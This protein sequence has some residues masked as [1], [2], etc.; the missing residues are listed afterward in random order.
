MMIKFRR[1]QEEI[2]DKY[3]PTVLVDA[4]QAKETIKFLDK[5]LSPLRILQKNELKSS[6]RPP[7]E[8]NSRLEIY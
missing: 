1:Q 8:P 6:F 2:V 4:K 7:Q 3:K 5:K